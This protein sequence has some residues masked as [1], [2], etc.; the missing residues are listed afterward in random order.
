MTCEKICPFLKSIS[1]SF[2]LKPRGAEYRRLAQNGPTRGIQLNQYNF[3]GAYY[4]SMLCTGL[5]KLGQ[6]SLFDHDTL[7]YRVLSV[8]LRLLITT[9]LLIEATY[10]MRISGESPNLES[11]S[12]LAPWPCTEYIQII[13]RPGHERLLERGDNRCWLWAYEHSCLHSPHQC[14]YCWYLVLRHPHFH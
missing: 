12:T 4:S 10:R 9:L 3:D 13:V 2:W 6:V 14:S 7:S 5:L 11:N 1:N 8:K